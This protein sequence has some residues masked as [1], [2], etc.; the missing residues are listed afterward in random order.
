VSNEVAV[1]MT[2]HDI[3]AQEVKISE[4]LLTGLFWLKPEFYSFYSNEK[5]SRATFLNHHYGFFFGLGRYMAEN[6]VQKF[7]DITVEKTVQELGDN[8]IQKYNEYG[9]Y[10]T[11]EEIMDSV[12]GLEDNIQAY[13][14]DIVKYQVLKGYCEV[15]KSKTPITPDGKYDHR[16][17]NKDQII[18]FWN[19]K[20]NSIGLN[21]DNR[22]EEYDLLADLEKE[23]EEWDKNPVVGMDFHDS[24]LMTRICTGWDYG[25]L[26]ILGGFGGSGK[27]SFTVRKIFMSCIDNQEKLLVVANEQGI[28]DFRKA[29]VTTIMG[30]IYYSK[31]YEERQ[32]Y[33]FDRKRLNQGNFTDNERDLLRRAVALAGIMC[34]DETGLIKFVFMENYVIDD[35]KKIVRYYN[36]RGYR[37]LIIDTGKPSEGGQ[38]QQRWIQFT[39]D[40]KEIY[41]L[42]RKEGGGL[43]LA[44]W[45]TVQL[46]DNALRQRFLNEFCFG[47]SKKIKNEADVVFMYRYAWDDE[48]EDGAKALVV[49]RYFN[50]NYESDDPIHVANRQEAINKNQKTYCVEE[51]LKRGKRYIL[52]FTPKNRRGQDNKNGQDVLVMEINLNFNSW[53]EIGWTTVVDDKNYY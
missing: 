16:K 51:K 11:M 3:L 34:N 32:K 31:P 37:R 19:D 12:N 15:M 49:K 4:G 18:K 52:L 14:D 53:R 22:F 36:N 42:T 27:T 26:T 6:G 5:L 38:E 40:M 23:I 44:T 13:Y 45:V 1:K 39:E 10:E 30:I 35:L 29:L 47:E 43:N 8:V 48:Y 46:A 21:L 24:P 9:G 41:K 7:D 25:T 17:M 20:F 50:V 28:R 33:F 2:V